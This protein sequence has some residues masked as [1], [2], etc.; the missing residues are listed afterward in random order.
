MGETPVIDRR[1]KGTV[2]IIGTDWGEHYVDI[3]TA[4]ELT[5]QMTVVDSLD[6]S[7]DKR[8]REIW[9][10]VLPTAAKARICWKIDDRGWK[11]KLHSALR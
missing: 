4:S 11:E 8:N 7:S 5:R 2:S 1:L 3:E 10:P 9:A 6:I